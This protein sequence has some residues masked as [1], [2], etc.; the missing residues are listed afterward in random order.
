MK[1]EMDPRTGHM[2]PKQDDNIYFARSQGGGLI[3]D[4]K[5]NRKKFI[6]E[7]DGRITVLFGSMSKDNLHFYDMKDAREIEIRV[8]RMFGIDHPFANYRKF[9]KGVRENYIKT[10]DEFNE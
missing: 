6:I 9:L 2:M 4:D 1:F 7:R 3:I 5:K 10:F 8:K